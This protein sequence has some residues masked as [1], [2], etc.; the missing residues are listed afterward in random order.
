MNPSLDAARQAPPRPLN[1]GAGPAKL[2]ET[3]FEPGP[4][5]SPL[6]FPRQAW[7]ASS[8]AGAVPPEPGTPRRE[9][10][11]APTGCLSPVLACPVCCQACGARLKPHRV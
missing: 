8:T 2:D 4:R 9:V 5:R 3:R 10:E 6:S 7:A 11:T 1:P